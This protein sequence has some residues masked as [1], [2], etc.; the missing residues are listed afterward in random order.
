MTAKS[1]KYRAP[2]DAAR[3]DE[4]IHGIFTANRQANHKAMISSLR[5]I[6]FGVGI[7][8]ARRHGRNR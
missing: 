1:F 8:A 6:I 5:A 3:I 7:D 2:I 4:F